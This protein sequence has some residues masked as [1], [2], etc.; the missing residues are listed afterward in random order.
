LAAFVS[1]TYFSRLDALPFRGE[2][3]RWA[4]VAWEM[5]E[6]GDWI[7]PRQQGQ[8]FADRPP[9]NS[10]CMLLVSGLTGSLDRFSVRLPAAL[11]TLLTA[12]LLYGYCRQFLTRWGAFTAG[13]V[14]GTFPQT[15][16]LGRFA[17]S[18]AVFTFL[19]TAALL[20]WH[21]GYARNWP[22]A[23][24]WIAGYVLAALS[25]L[26]KGPQ[27]PVYF[28][29]TVT[30]FFGLRRDWRCLF[31][32]AHLAGL[33][34]FAAVLGAWQIPFSLAAGSGASAAVWSEE[35]TLGDRLAGIFGKIWWR[36]LATYPVE[37]FAYLLPWSVFLFAVFRPSLW[38]REA[39]GSGVSFHVGGKTD[40]CATTADADM[41]KDSRPLL[42]LVAYVAI[43][44]PTCWLV[45]DARPRH[46]MAIY[47]AVACLIAA[48]IDR[49]CFDR[50]APRWDWGFRWFLAVE[51]A[52]GVLLGLAVLI[53]GI[54][55]AVARVT[56]VLSPSWSTAACGAAIVALGAV[57]FW[58]WAG[59]GPTR[60]AAG[61]AAVG[62]TLALGFVVLAIDHFGRIAD[63]LEA[64]V[65]RLK[66]D[67]L[68]GERLVSFAPLFHKFTFYYE[69]PI[70]L[71]P[72]PT[73][74]LP[75]EP[76]WQ[77]FAF[78]SRETR[79]RGKLPFAWEEVAAVYCDRAREKGQNIVYIG[80]PKG[81]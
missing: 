58:T 59:F 63:D 65:A 80:R 27:G 60:A 8:V 50:S 19:L 28:V 20:V 40:G 14:Y 35:G 69:D 37:V 22:R 36:H 42:L 73:G 33:F 62:A 72:W 53:A 16:Q 30:V 23:W 46:L 15:L 34:A 12:L 56:V 5:R 7:V 70:E 81:R 61:I 39:K 24:T 47:P 10:W 25:G 54:C 67:I 38:R 51:G 55:P 64:Q 11:A 75:E 32:L 3:T 74:K 1:V 68:R 29:A 4:R 43:A 21:T 79:I 45:T 2:E 77:Y 78:M 41:E 52:L 31:S 48:V 76:T 49:S 71:L 57:C 13:L 66:S 9:L 26:A 44:F 6:T 17:E 18:D